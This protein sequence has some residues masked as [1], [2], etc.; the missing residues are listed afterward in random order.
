LQIIW[1]CGGHYYEALHNQIDTDTY[2]RLRMVDFLHQMAEAYAVADVVV[3]RAGAL[4]CAE[5]A[6]TGKAGILVPSPNVAGDHQ[7][8]N[9]QAMVKSGAACLL[10][11]EDVKELLPELVEKLINDQQKRKKMQEAALKMARPNA[12]KEIAGGILKTLSDDS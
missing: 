4:A 1:Q 2:P 9:A 7:T 8:K 11:D 10:K 6:L 3:S 12:A 5:I